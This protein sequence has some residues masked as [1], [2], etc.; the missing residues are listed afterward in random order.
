MSKIDASVLLTARVPPALVAALDAEAQ[1][2]HVETGL[3]CSR[4]AALIRIL[5][6]ALQ[7]PPTPAASSAPP[8]PAPKP[9]RAKAPPLDEDALRARCQAVPNYS[10]LLAQ[11]LRQKPG[12][13]RAW[14][15]GRSHWDEARL[16]KVARWLDR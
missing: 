11:A 7:A 12:T 15:N 8:A 3:P 14:A 16:A 4:S 10:N 5:T 6:R 13:V 1:R 9:A 2:L